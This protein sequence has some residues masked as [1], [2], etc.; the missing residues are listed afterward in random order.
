MKVFR[1]P[2]D[3]FLSLTQDLHYESVNFSELLDPSFYKS[4]HQIETKAKLDHAP[5][6]IYSMAIRFVEFSNGDTKL[7]IF[8]PK[9]QHTQRK[10]LNFEIWILVIDIF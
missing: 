5:C 9:N 1:L 4:E 10:L 6:C 7:K 3:Y 2:R 8:L